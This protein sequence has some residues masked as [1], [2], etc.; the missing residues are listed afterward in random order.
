MPNF[1]DA[2][3]LFGEIDRKFLLEVF[4]CKLTSQLNSAH[5]FQEVHFFERT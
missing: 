1:K 3:V 5:I 4:R 2:L